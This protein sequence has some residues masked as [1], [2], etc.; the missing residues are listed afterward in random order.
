MFLVMTDHRLFA[1]REEADD[2]NPQIHLRRSIF[3]PRRI[4][5]QKYH[6]LQENRVHIGLLN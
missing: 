3:G 1:N 5:Q 4:T 6:Q 2:V